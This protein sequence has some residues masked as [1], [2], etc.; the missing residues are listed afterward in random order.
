MTRAARS[1]QWG[2]GKGRARISRE[3]SGAGATAC[4]GLC[5]VGEAVRCT[6]R[7]EGVATLTT[8]AHSLFPIE[9]ITE[10]EA[11]K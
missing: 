6:R 9:R 11:G 10:E 1:P 7:V 8:V 5:P 2:R 4:A 3:G